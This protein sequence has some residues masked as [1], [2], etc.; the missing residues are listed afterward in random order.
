MKLIPVNNIP[1]ECILSEDVAFDEDDNMWD[2]WQTKQLFTVGCC[3]GHIRFVL[4]TDDTILAECLPMFNFNNGFN[5]VNVKTLN[6]WKKRLI[7]TEV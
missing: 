4:D 3:L 5:L 6:Q 7:K 1:T 2:V